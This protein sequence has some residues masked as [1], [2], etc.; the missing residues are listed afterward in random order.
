MRIGQ[1]SDGSLIIGCRIDQTG[2][3]KPVQPNKQPYLLINIK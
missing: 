2:M 3:A 1:I